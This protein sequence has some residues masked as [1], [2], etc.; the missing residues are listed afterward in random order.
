MKVIYERS[1]TDESQIKAKHDDNY[2]VLISDNWDDFGF[3][4]S[5]RTFCRIKGEYFDLGSIR[6]LIAN[7]NNTHDADVPPI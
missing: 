5:C 4:T 7:G 2:I 1:L 6:L 3:K